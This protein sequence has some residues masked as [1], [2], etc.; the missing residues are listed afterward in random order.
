MPL[1]ESGDVLTCNECGCEIDV[2]EDYC[3]VCCSH[4]DCCRCAEEEDSDD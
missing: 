1:N 4:L 2:G 3:G